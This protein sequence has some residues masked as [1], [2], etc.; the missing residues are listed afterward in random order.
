MSTPTSAQQPNP[1][2]IFDMLNAYQRS[3]ALKAAID[4]DLFT[5]IARGKRTA[6]DIA[7][8]LKAPE[9]GVRILCDYLV[10]N[11]MLAKSGS[12]YIPSL[13]A[14]I[15]LNRDSPAYFGDSAN[16]LLN[17]TLT[18]PYAQLSEVV[19]TGKTTLPEQGTVSHDNPIWVDFARYM[20]KLMHPAAEEIADLVA[21]TGPMTILDIAAGHGWFGISA[22]VK[23]PQAEVTAL[24]WPNVLAVAKE[25]AKQAGVSDR[26]KTIPGDAFTVDYGG[27][28][29]LVLVTNFFHH[30]DM[31]TCEQIMRKIHASLAPGGRCVNA[32]FVCNEDRVTP[33]PQASFALMM[34]GTTESGD[35]YTFAEYDRM[36]RKAG[37]GS[38]ELVWLHK[39]LQGI[40]I[41]NRD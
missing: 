16:F 15:F 22:A 12:E 1:G 37:F 8:E 39:S 6:A 31:P 5:I 28:Y 27:P 2:I 33:P 13:E 18:S 34:L 29:D 17:P 21:G 7:G 14:G 11:G 36:Y 40:I 3:A 41:T 35:V 19:R 26:H 24:D 20:G 25:N 10:I 30:F 32:D 9:R 4:L 23:N 38:S